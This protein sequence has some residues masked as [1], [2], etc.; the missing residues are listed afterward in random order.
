MVLPAA[1]AGKARSEDVADAASADCHRHVQVATGFKTLTDA[2]NASQLAAEAGVTSGWNTHLCQHWSCK[3]V[4]NDLACFG[5]LCLCVY[6]LLEPSR[7]NYMMCVPG[8]L[9]PWQGKMGRVM[10][11][12][13]LCSTSFLDVFS[14]GPHFGSTL[15]WDTTVT[16][17]L[18]S[19]RCSSSRGQC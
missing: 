6:L 7:L 10:M 1:P 16:L 15:Q 9:L 4:H 12:P 3:R 11:S 2:A 14:V 17:W 19:L 13:V 18:W 8:V 5:H